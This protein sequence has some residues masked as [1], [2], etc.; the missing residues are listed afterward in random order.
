MNRKLLLVAVLVALLCFLLAKYQDAD[1]VLMISEYFGKNPAVALKGKV[2]WITGASSG[3]GEYL[4]YELSKCGCK[5][6]L[7][8][9]RKEE[10]ERVKEKCVGKISNSIELC[11]TG[12]PMYV[13]VIL[14]DEDLCSESFLSLSVRSIMSKS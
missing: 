12:W 2:F 8:A 1:M 11:P 10:L 9:R 5:L 3:I 13:L 7:S 4:A 14:R 6:V